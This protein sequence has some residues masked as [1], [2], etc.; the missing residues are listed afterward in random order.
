MQLPA[1]FSANGFSYSYRAF[2]SYLTDDIADTAIP[3]PPPVPVPGQ[4]LPPAPEPASSYSDKL[5]SS[6]TRH[7][8]MIA[9][10]CSQEHHHETGLTSGES[11]SSSF[12]TISSEGEAEEEEKGLSRSPSV[13]SHRMSSEEEESHASESSSGAHPHRTI[14]PEREMDFELQI[15]LWR[16]WGRLRLN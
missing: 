5:K 15:A 2:P 6:L 1:G 13:R 10:Y 12:S 3:A 9:S 11:S 14:E 7:Y 16:R 8:H 4:Y